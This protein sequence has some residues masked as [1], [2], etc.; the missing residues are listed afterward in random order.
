MKKILVL[1]TILFW[2][3]NVFAVGTPT[4]YTVTVLEIRL[5]TTGDEWISIGMPNQSI[6]I[7]AATANQVAGTMAASLAIPEGQYDNYMLILSNT[8]TVTG[9]ADGQATGSGGTVTMTGADANANST[10]TWDQNTAPN[11]VFNAGL[12]ALPNVNL[13]DAGDVLNAAGNPQQMTFVLNL[14]AV[15]GRNDGKIQITASADQTPITI[16]PVAPVTI[17]FSFDVTGTIAYD[18]AN[19]GARMMFFP[20]AEGTSF[21]ITAGG[22]SLTVNAANMQMDF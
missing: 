12:G 9:V 7:A 4:E 17:S 6:N 1:L 11:P 13:A 21:T 8:F 15:G 22:Q 2:G 5:K 14:G 19:L 10:S 18:L 16:D 20:P 3:A